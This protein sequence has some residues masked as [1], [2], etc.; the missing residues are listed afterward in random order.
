MKGAI[1]TRWKSNIEL[2]LI[3]GNYMIYIVAGNVEFGGVL[4]T[5][6]VETDDPVFWKAQHVNACACV[7][8]RV[9]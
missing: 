5:R 8:A 9:V 7:C 4:C 6:R 2:R 1:L 3:A